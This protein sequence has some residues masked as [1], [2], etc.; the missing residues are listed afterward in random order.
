M[1]MPVPKLESRIEVKLT[2]EGREKL[3]EMI[4][5]TGARDIDELVRDTFRVYDIIT[6]DVFVHGN[7]M[8]VRDSKSGKISRLQLWQRPAHRGH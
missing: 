2:P 7:Q 4:Q 6:E 8:L 5:R 1:S 3:D